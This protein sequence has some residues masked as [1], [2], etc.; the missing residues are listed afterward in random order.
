MPGPD[1]EQTLKL[2]EL[3]RESVGRRSPAIPALAT[4]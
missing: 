1:P 2:H 4:E 3:V